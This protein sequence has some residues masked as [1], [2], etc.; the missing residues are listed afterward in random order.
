MSQIVTVHDGGKVVT[1]A[2]V[3][4]PCFYDPTGAR[5]NA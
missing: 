4:A 1:T 5:M 3:V 2:Q